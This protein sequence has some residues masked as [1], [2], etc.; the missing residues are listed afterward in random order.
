M[1]DIASDFTASSTSNEYSNLELT[2]V[3]FKVSPF[4]NP[5]L[6]EGGQFD[7]SIIYSVTIFLAIGPGSQ[8]F[9]TL[10]LNIK[11]STW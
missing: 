9:L 5:I 4:F 1:D 10:L 11:V 8:E 7:H 3:N 2:R 6:G